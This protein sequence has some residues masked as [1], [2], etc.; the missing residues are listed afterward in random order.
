MLEKDP[1]KVLIGICLSHGGQIDAGELRDLLVPEYLPEDKWPRWWSRAR[2]A[3]RR[4]ETLSVE[5]RNPAVIRYHPDGRSLEQELAG[6]A[7]K[8]RLP[9][10]RFAVLQQYLREL[11]HRKLEASKEF[12]VPIM[13][14]LAEQAESFRDHR[15]VE[16]LEAVL[17][18]QA[19]VAAGLPAPSR[20][21][22]QVDELLSEMNDPAESVA[23]L[24][25]PSLWPPALE[26]LQ[27]RED[28]AAQ[29]EKLLRRM[30]ANQLDG[31]AK[32][33]LAMGRR[34]AVEQA[35]AEAIANP[36]KNLQ[37]CLWLWRGS[38]ETG[39]IAPSK[40]EL[41]SRLL[42]AA[43]AI[44][45]DADIE[46]NVRRTAF[47][48]IRSALLME[49]GERFR[50][51]LKETDEATAGTIK[52]RIERSEMLSNV[53]REDLLKILREEFYGLFVE[54][55]VEPWL[56]E[57]TIWTT[58]RALREQEAKLKE[59]LE[60]TMPANSRAIGEAAEKGDL[61]E[62]SEWQFAIE[63]RRR[64]QA[65]AAQMQDELTMARTLHADDVPTD[66]VG[67]GSRVRLRPTAGG[68]PVELTFLG[69]WDSD[70]EKHVYSY[71][72]PI[73]LAVMGKKAGDLV[74]LQLAGKEAE[75]II[76]SI[77][78]AL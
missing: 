22:P 50:S 47:Q 4:S 19:A 57:G 49:G 66:H 3:A 69:P 75:Y 9:L 39:G 28:A 54:K 58:D 6:A 11:K 15:P 37:L 33:L 32:R 13:N 44:S 38:A 31:I 51:A 56:D 12:A 73:A 74:T 23:R 35:A 61:S 14:A 76:E 17:A 18:I 2:T 26:A 68:E 48:E 53:A 59:L 65:R 46:R 55:K 7:A 30:P 16:S 72:T 24:G 8:A 63:E 1:A 77:A 27:R 45:G 21:F 41:L 34:E 70:V 25:E 42:S 43:E 71:R 10:E 62:N 29:F 36:A 40:L 67:I 64:L 78:S 5:G 60:V 20:P 52:R